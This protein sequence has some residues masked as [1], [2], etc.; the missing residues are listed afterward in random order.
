MMTT[1]ERLKQL[2]H[3]LVQMNDEIEDLKAALK[4]HGIKVTPKNTFV[5]T[6]LMPIVVG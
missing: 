6:K 5:E 1:D 4:S 3:I 2:E